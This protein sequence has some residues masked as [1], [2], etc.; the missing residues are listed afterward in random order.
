[1]R[2]GRVYNFKVGSLVR[3]RDGTVERGDEIDL[4][5]K[6]WRKWYIDQC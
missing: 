1:M 6:P 2:E 3:W 4:G 5:Q